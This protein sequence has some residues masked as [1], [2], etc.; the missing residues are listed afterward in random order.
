MGHSDCGNSGLSGYLLL[1][2][3]AVGLLMIGT[4]VSGVG[5]G[6]SGTELRGSHQAQILR[7]SASQEIAGQ[8]LLANFNLSLETKENADFLL[9]PALLVQE[10]LRDDTVITYPTE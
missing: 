1:I 6:V 9:T 8:P 5:N 10:A 2:L 3:C 7:E 4:Q